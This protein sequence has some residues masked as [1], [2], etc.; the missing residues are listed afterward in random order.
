MTIILPEGA[1]M[2]PEEMQISIR[3]IMGRFYRFKYMFSIAF[4]IL[5]FPMLVLYLHNLK[6]GWRK[7]HRA[8]RNNLLR[9]GGWLILRRWTSQFKKGTFPSKLKQ[10]QDDLM[11]QPPPASAT[12]LDPHGA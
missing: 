11:A 1:P 2:V 8:W 5:S 10:A 12:R 6:S 4:N 9:F 3:K 7:W